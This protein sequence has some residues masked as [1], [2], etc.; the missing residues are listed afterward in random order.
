MKRTT[1]LLLIPLFG[2]FSCFQGDHEP[3]TDDAN[4][5]AGTGN[6]I[7][8][9]EV[10]GMWLLSTDY[11]YDERCNYLPEEFVRNLFKLPEDADLQKYESMYGCEV[12]W[13]KNK[14]GFSFEGQKSFESTFQSEYVF[15]KKYQPELA[16]AADSAAVRKAPYTGPVTQGVGAESPA[17]TSTQQKAPSTTRNDRASATTNNIPP[18][19]SR[20][21]Q[22]A[23]NTPTGVAVAGVGD[24]AIWEPGK[25]T[26][27]V[28][29]NNHILHVMAQLPGKP[30]TIKQGTID[31]A[32]VII[33][34]LNNKEA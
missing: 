30:D 21:T 22:P 15:N 1:L 18:Q 20:I 31:L 32:K 29:Y 13:G 34:T 27:H 10:V 5:A 24:K 26:L 23:R 7:Q 25:Q 33:S 17:D 28:L 14:V 4:D 19:A 16:A 9:R 8:A 6:D 3:Q 11:N 12:H 2:L